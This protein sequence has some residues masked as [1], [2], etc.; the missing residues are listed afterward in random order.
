MEMIL[1][2][3][4]GHDSVARRGVLHL[5][6]TPMD[7]PATG[8]CGGAAGGCIRAVS[9]RGNSRFPLHLTLISGLN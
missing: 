6:L 5:H 3:A 2:L 1:I 8:G 4:R 9:G 7:A